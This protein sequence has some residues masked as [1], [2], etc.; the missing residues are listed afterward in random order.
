M[1]QTKSASKVEVTEDDI[2]IPNP[3]F[4]GACEEIRTI[5]LNAKAGVKALYCVTNKTVKTYLFD[6]TMWSVEEA[7]QWV[8]DHSKEFEDAYVKA[9]VIR[10]GKDIWAVAS[11]T[12]ED[13][14]GDVVDVEGWD[15]SNFKSNPVLLWMH[16]RANGHNGLPIGKAERI[17]YKVVNGA[18]KLVFKPVFDD[19]TDFNRTVK[20]F[21]EDGTLNAFSVGFLPKDEG[22]QELLEISGVPVPALQT[23]LVISRMKEMNMPK[24]KLF[25]L[26]EVKRAIPH[27]H[28]PLAAES[29]GWDSNGAAGRAK[30][31][32]DDSDEKYRQAFAWYDQ[33]DPTAPNA[34]KLSHHDVDGTNLVTVWKG[35]VSAMALLL[36]GAVAI[37]ESDR[38][39]VYDHLAE[40]YR[41]FDKVA[42]DYKLIETQ[43][44]KEVLDIVTEE[45]ERKTYKQ[46]KKLMTDLRALL[47]EKKKAQKTISLDS[48]H[49]AA[50]V[51]KGLSSRVAETSRKKGGK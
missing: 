18:K 28:Y 4:T 20:K 10:E 49:V 11:E 37:P 14:D 30:I 33:A 36:R 2:R 6:K 34:Y 31:W 46:T 13:R 35:V 38:K 16:N 25:D 12:I 23:A 32:A 27:R 48:N 26:V 22:G 29:R 40:H 1:E 9:G 24:E 47:N 51:L 45:T 8:Q 39:A 21:Y 15:I 44:L 17:G 3:K 7:K 42:P 41:E 19:S 5:D 43:E 50:L